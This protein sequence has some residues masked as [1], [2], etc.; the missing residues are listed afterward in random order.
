MMFVSSLL[1][2]A[3]FSEIWL[4]IH[5]KVPPSGTARGIFLPMDADQTQI[6]EISCFVSDHTNH[7][8]SIGGIPSGTE[9][10]LL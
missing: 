2:S 5:R 1:T 3:A 10:K 4:S 8:I 9:D 7:L 6:S